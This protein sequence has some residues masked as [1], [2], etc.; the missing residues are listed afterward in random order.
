VDLLRDL[1]DQNSLEAI[2]KI[3]IPTVGRKDQLAWTLDP[4]GNFTVKSAV[5]LQ[6]PLVLQTHYMT[7][8]G[9][10]CGNSNFM[11]D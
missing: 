3:V 2:Q 9:I 4:K 5:K 7:L 10:P 6:Q 8:Y 1:V 11:K